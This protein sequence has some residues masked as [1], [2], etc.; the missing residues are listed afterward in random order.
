MPYNFVPDSFH[1]GVTAEAL[2]AKIYRKSAISHQRRHFD[3]KF[4]V[5]GGCPAPIIFTR[6][7]RPLRVFTQRNFVADF[8]QAKCIFNENRPFCVFESP[9]GA[10]YD[11]HLRL[12]GKRVV[13]FLLALIELF[14]LGVTAEALRAIKNG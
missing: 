8:L 12:I 14:S 4:Q 7:V 1:T 9:L 13:D 10:T 3:P 6:L 2:R 11:D 5:P